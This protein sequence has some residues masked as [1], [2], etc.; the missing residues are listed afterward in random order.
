MCLQTGMTDSDYPSLCNQGLASIPLVGPVRHVPL[1][2]ELSEQFTH[3][4]CNCVMGLLPQISMYC[5]LHLTIFM[6]ECCLHFVSKNIDPLSAWLHKMLMCSEPDL[7]ISQCAAQIW[8]LGQSPQEIFRA[9]YAI[10][11]IS[12][13][14]YAAEIS[15]VHRTRFAKFTLFAAMLK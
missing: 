8:G 1:P 3:I 7:E 11:A 9:P 14:Q 15:N 13:Y 10:L 6:L 4:Q 12:K 2:V 5:F